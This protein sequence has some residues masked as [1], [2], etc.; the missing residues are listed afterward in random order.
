MNFFAL[1]MT[2]LSAAIDAQC[3]AVPSNAP[4]D[5]GS[6][7][8]TPDVTV[9]LVDANGTMVALKPG[10]DSTQDS[11]VQTSTAQRI[12]LHS[13]QTGPMTSNFASS[14]HCQ[15]MV[16][17]LQNDLFGYWDTWEYDRYAIVIITAGTCAVL[18]STAVLPQPGH[19][20]IGNQDIA[21]AVSTIIADYTHDGL[22]AGATQFNCNHP[23]GATMLDLTVQ[24]SPKSQRKPT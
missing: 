9:K 17:Y 2:L 14:D 21:E 15:Q 4:R 12:C 18:I 20:W 24:A 3:A 16:N 23:L 6:A 19:V 22:V 5:G 1:L 13:D 7:P 8:V 11:F 10:G